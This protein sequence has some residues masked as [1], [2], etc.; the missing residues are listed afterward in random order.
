[1]LDLLWR[2]MWFCIYFVATFC[3]INVYSLYVSV[4]TWSDKTT[5]VLPQ[6]SIMVMQVSLV[7]SLS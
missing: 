7:I 5:S 4:L 1:M 6:W 2:R 3:V